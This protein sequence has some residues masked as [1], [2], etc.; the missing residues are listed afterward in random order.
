MKQKYHLHWNLW[1]EGNCQLVWKNDKPLNLFH[2]QSP[3]GVI[4]NLRDPFHQIPDQNMY[5]VEALT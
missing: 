1:R 2:Y 5:I 3:E 4:M